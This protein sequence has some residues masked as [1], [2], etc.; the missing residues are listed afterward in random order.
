MTGADAGI[1]GGNP[2]PD[3]ESGTGRR[4]RRE[5]LERS[6][7]KSDT[8][9]RRR[10]ESVER[11][12][13]EQAQVLQAQRMESLGQLAGGVAHDFGNLLAVILSYASFVRRMAQFRANPARRPP[14]SSPRDAACT[15]C[16]PPASLRCPE[17]PGGRSPNRRPTTHGRCCGARPRS[18]A[19]YAP[20][21]AA[22]AR[23]QSGSAGWRPPTRRCTERPAYG[24]SR[25]LA[26]SVMYTARR[27]S[28]LS[29][30]APVVPHDH[31]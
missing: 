20:S 4:E 22:R 31:A 11:K 7:V 26:R 25:I 23:C 1:G 21:S 16:P 28:G 8:G 6:D 10:R 17:P 3:V 18:P 29:W 9:R 13:R 30:P 14:I 15:A 19:T 27:S 5:S 12:E 2:D 24:A